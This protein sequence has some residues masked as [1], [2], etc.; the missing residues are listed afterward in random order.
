MKENLT[1][2]NVYLMMGIFM[3]VF[4]IISW[5]KIGINESLS[6]KWCIYS[7]INEYSEC[8]RDFDFILDL[9]LPC[10]VFSLCIFFIVLGANMILEYY[11]QS[12]G[13]KCGAKKPEEKKEGGS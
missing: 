11:T 3:L 2:G 8:I 6:E 13:C 7:R 9:A 5:I 12:S 1:K 10:G 4:S